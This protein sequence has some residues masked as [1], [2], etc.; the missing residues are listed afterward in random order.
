M[1]LCKSSKKEMVILKLDFEKSF[2]KIEH[3]VICKILEQKGFGPKWLKW[4]EMIMKSSTYAMLLNGVPGTLFKCKREVQQ[5]DPLSSLLFVLVADLLQPI[6]NKAKDMGILNL[7]IQQRRG[8][9]FAIIQY[10]DDT[11][12]V[13]EAFQKQ[14]FFLKA[15][16]NTYVESTRLRVNYSKSNIYPINVSTEKMQILANTF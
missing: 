7:P 5:G 6:I 16:L 1:H 10:A 4:M 12:L 3:D 13:L 15:I 14:L 8:Q 9:D 2:D 11:I